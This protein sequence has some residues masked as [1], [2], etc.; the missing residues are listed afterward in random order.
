M[1]L[2]GRYGIKH[3]R[4]SGYNSHANGIVERT[5]FDV[6]QALFK[7][8]D[9]DKSKWSFHAHSVF[10][11]DRVTVRRWMGVSPYFVVTG[12]QPLLPLDFSEATCL[13]LPPSQ[14]LTTTELIVERAA[15][16]E[17]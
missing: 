9:G 6:R 15:S 2:E 8:S 1:E 7:A 17:K 12:A 13:R 10:W 16:L 5:H 11:A 3:I 14:F 4:I